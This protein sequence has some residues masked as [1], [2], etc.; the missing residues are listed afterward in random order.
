MSTRFHRT[1][2][3]GDL[4]IPDGVEL[5]D[6]KPL[7]ESLYDAPETGPMFSATVDGE[8]VHLFADEIKE[9]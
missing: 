3:S 9:A 1:P 7:D 8:T 4:S 6:V 5:V 2:N